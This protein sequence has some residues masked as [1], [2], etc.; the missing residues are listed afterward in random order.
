M[1]LSDWSS[2]VCSSDLR[3][4][5]ASEHRAAKVRGRGARATASEFRRQSTPF[6]DILEE[7]FQGW[8]GW[9]L[10]RDERALEITLTSR[11]EERSGRKT[12]ACVDE[13]GQRRQ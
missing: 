8:G 1:C 10:E 7:F 5:A 9:P 12:P 3:R 13:P 11:S 4:L 2:V 6:G